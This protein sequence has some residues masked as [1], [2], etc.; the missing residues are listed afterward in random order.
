MRR[1]VDVEHLLELHDQLPVLLAHVLPEVILQQVD[2]L[3]RDAAHQL[4]LNA[5]QALQSSLM[6]LD[7]LPKANVP[8]RAGTAHHR[9]KTRQQL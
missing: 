6:P 9:D 1:S 3:A 7:T 5:A 8:L 4:V 2:G